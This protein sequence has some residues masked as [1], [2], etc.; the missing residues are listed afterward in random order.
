MKKHLSHV[1]KKKKLGRLFCKSGCFQR[2][3]LQRS[4][5]NKKIKIKDFNI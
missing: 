1:T 4:A 2:K 3:Q 5:C